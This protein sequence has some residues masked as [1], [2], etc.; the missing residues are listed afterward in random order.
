MNNEVKKIE[1]SIIRECRKHEWCRDCPYDDNNNCSITL[2]FNNKDVHFTSE[3]TFLK[4]FKEAIT[5]EC[6]MAEDC[7]SCEKRATCKYSRIPVFWK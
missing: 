1:K 2:V 7:K 5:K 4:L 3:T 6:E